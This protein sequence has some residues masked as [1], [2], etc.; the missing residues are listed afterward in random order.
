MKA[1]WSAWIGSLPIN[2]FNSLLSLFKLNIKYA[3]T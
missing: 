3:K 1:C 2:S